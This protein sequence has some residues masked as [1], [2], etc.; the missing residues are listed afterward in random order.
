MDVSLNRNTGIEIDVHSA[1]Y[2]DLMKAQPCLHLQHTCSFHEKKNWWFTNF[3]SRT[4]WEEEHTVILVNHCI[5]SMSL[6]LSRHKE[7]GPKSYYEGYFRV[8]TSIV[9]IGQHIIFMC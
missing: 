6:H 5:R 2:I 8:A 3:S 1:D 9:I 7:N 4:M